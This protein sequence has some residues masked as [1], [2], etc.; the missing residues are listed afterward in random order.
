MVK[1]EVSRAYVDV[2]RAVSDAGIAVMAHIGIRPQYIG[3][4]G[5]F[6]AEG[7]TA[8]MGYEL[9]SLADAMVEAGASALLIEGTAAEVAAHVTERSGGAG[10]QLRIRDRTAM[11][12]CSLPPISLG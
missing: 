1:F 2:V 9:M 10:D 6:K 11:A 5:R 3:K 7:T 12:R 4:F 8:E